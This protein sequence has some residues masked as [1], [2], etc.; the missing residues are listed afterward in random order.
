MGSNFDLSVFA[1]NVRDE[2]YLTYI[3]GTFNTLS[4]ESVQVGLPK[5]VGARLR[6]SFGS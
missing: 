6:Y 4:F 3:S 1:T 2:E 5:M